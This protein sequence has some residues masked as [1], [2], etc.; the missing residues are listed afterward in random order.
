MTNAQVNC[1]AG[2]FS[3]NTK[4]GISLF[5]GI[6]YAKPITK[7]AQWHPPEK[8][9]SAI[10]FEANKP[11]FSAPQTIYRNSFLCLRVQLFNF[12]FYWFN[13]KF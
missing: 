3:G 12:R 5:F 6:P 9:K 13:C 1:K 10:V 4:G 7:K 8:I 11:G 2:N